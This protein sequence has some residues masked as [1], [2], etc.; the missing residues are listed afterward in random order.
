MGGE[1]GEGGHFNDCEPN[2]SCDGPTQT[3]PVLTETTFSGSCS[4]PVTCTSVDCVGGDD[5]NPTVVTD[6]LRCC[7]GAWYDLSHGGVTASVSDTL[8]GGE[9]AYRAGWLDPLP[10]AC[11]GTVVPSSHALHFEGVATF[12]DISIPLLDAQQHGGWST[13]LTFEAWFRTTAAVAPLMLAYDDVSWAAVSI[14]V[15][16]G[17][18]CFHYEVGVNPPFHEIC[19]ATRTL[20]DGAWHHAA[21]VVT[22]SRLELFEDGLVALD[23]PQT[24]PLALPALL[25]EVTL[26]RGAVGLQG[27]IDFLPGDLDE[28][29]FWYGTR[30]PREIRDY[31]ATGLTTA[32]KPD[33]GGPYLLGYYRLD[34]SGDAQTLADS[35][36]AYHVVTW[37][38]PLRPYPTSHPGELN[39]HESGSPWITPGAF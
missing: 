35:N 25:D 15:E 7:D 5:T 37:E 22:A 17:G 14:N 19:T 33:D 16:N 4:E 32:P 38:T 3:P 31:R 28:V 6:S 39:L 18:V 36:A 21:V 10:P 24:P 2:S 1:I 8:D 9:R 12:A 34:E 20:N 29:R 23:A 13:G 26:G 11:G 30:T 27:D